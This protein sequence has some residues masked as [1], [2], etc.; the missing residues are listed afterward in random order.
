MPARRIMCASK[1]GLIGLTKSLAQEVGSRNI[2]VNAV[3]PGFIETDMTQ[4]ASQEL[5]G[6]NGL[7]KHAIAGRMGSPEDIASAVKFLVSDEASVHYRP[8]AGR[9]RRNLHVSGM[10]ANRDSEFKIGLVQMSCST[11]ADANLGRRSRQSARRRRRARRLSV[12]RNYFAANTSAA[13][14]TLPFSIWPKRFRD[15]QRRP[16]GR[17]RK[18]SEWRW[19]RRYLKSAHKGYITI[20]RHYRCGVS[21]NGIYRKMHIPDDPLYYEKFYFTPGDLGFQNFDTRY[22]VSAC[23]C[24]GTNGIRKPLGSRDAR[25]RTYFLSDCNW[26]ASV[27]ESAV[28]RGAIGCVAYDSARA[29]DC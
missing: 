29:C 24:A 22:H 19:S 17:L 3:A 15:R 2:T 26:L 11:G 9:E 4:R 10:S 12:C 20:R 1:A 18:I 8:R 14:R 21:L 25:A 6:Q 28:W 27:R 16:S 13:K 5:K 7:G 23:W